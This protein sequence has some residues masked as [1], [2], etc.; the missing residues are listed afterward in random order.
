MQKMACTGNKPGR[1]RSDLSLWC[2]ISPAAVVKCGTDDEPQRL[3]AHDL[4][5]F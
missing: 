5:K 3:C 2:A 1:L 4:G